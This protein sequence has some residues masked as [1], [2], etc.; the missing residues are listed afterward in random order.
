MKHFVNLLFLTSSIVPSNTFLITS[1]INIARPTSRFSYFKIPYLEMDKDVM[2][3]SEYIPYIDEPSFDIHIIVNNDI[4]KFTV[5]NTN[6]LKVFEFNFLIER[7]V[8][9]EGNNIFTF[10]FY[11]D[12]DN[13]IKEEYIVSNYFDKEIDISSLEDSSYVG[14]VYSI[15]YQNYEFNYLC[16]KISF[17][18]FEKDYYL[19]YPRFRLR[20]LQI[21]TKCLNNNYLLKI[22]INDYL[23]SKTYLNNID[24]YLYELN[25]SNICYNKYSFAVSESVTNS[26]YSSDIYFPLNIKEK[27]VLDLNI[28]LINISFH[29]TKF[30]FNSKIHFKPLYSYSG[31]GINDIHFVDDSSYCPMEITKEVNIYA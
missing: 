6:P 20:D 3:E 17:I 28:E 9:K 19:D 18:N 1:N 2:F 16:D 10:L 13:P 12:K 24:F 26:F 15:E 21:K 5:N 23:I 31:V 4:Y 11:I 29:S 14:E 22:K 7:S 30:V 8:I 27:T 25:V